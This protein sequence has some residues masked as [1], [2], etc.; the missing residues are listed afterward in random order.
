M[1][2]RQRQWLEQWQA[3]QDDATF[4]FHEWI[5]PNTLLDFSGKTVL[6]AG[7]GGGQ[8]TALIAP[9]CER[10]VAVDLNAVDIAVQRNKHGNVSF[11]EED[12]AEMNLGELYDIVLCIGVIHHTDDPEKTVAN[13]TRHLRPGGRIILWVYSKEGNWM[14]EQIVERVRLALLSNRKTQTL[15]KLAQFI[16]ALLY[17]PVYTVYMLPIPRL[18]YFEYFQNFRRLTYSRNT[19]NVFDKLNSPQVQFISMKRAQSWLNP[20]RFSDI[21]ISSYVGVSWRISATLKRT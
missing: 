19:L 11:L 10:V 6:E 1:Q 12:I 15:S 9:I 17:A 5:R 20:E 21:H 16:T 4:L 3:Y 7:C 14:A 18:P 8:H 2:A 13:L